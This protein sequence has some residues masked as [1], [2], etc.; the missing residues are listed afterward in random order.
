MRA[1]NEAETKQNMAS[2]R[3]PYLVCSVSQDLS[4]N[5]YIDIKLQI[6]SILKITHVFMY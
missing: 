5:I 3:K 1:E 6:F 2:K 4:A